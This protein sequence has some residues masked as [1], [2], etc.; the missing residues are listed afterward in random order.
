MEL[1]FN[2]R[3]IILILIY[4]SIARSLNAQKLP[5]YT[6]TNQNY[7]NDLK[8]F[9]DTLWVATSG[10]VFTM[11]FEDRKIQ[12]YATNNE[13]ADNNIRKVFIDKDGVKWFSSF[14]AI[15]EF[16]KRMIK[17]YAVPKSLASN[18]VFSFGKSMDGKLWIGTNGGEALIQIDGADTTK[19]DSQVFTE[20]VVWDMEGNGESLWFGTRDGAY[21]YNDGG[22]TRF[23]TPDG[24]IDNW[25][26]GLAVVDDNNVWIGTP[27][28]LTYY[29]GTSLSS[30]TTANSGIRDNY[31]VDIS[32][33]G[34]HVWLAS[35]SNLSYLKENIWRNISFGSPASIAVTEDGEAYVGT[36][37]NGISRV[38]EDG[39]VESILRPVTIP[40]NVIEDI[41]GDLDGNIWIATRGGLSKY[42]GFEFENFTTSSGLSDDFIFDVEVDE[43]NNVWIGT[44]REIAKYDGSKWESIA[45]EDVRSIASDG[46]GA[47][48]FGTISNGLFKYDGELSQFTTDDG[49]VSNSITSLVFDDNDVLWIGSSS[50]LMLYDGSFDSRLGSTNIRSLAVDSIN[51]VWAGTFDAGIMILEDRSL[52]NTLYEDDLFGGF[53]IRDIAFIDSKVYCT[54]EDGLGVYSEGEWFTYA[55]GDGLSSNIR[56]IHN[57]GTDLWVGSAGGLSFAK[58]KANQPPTDIALSKNQFDVE[59]ATP[60]RV[61]TL[62]AVDASK[63]DMHNF[64]ILDVSTSEADFFISENELWINSL[65]NELIETAEVKLKAVDLAGE[66][67]EIVLTI[68]FFDSMNDIPEITAYKGVSSINEDVP[69]AIKLEDFEVSDP[70][71]IFPEEFL[72]TIVQMENFS[73]T[74]NTITPNTDY[75]GDLEVSVIISDDENESTPFN[76]TVQVAPV[77]DIPEIVNQ[78]TELTISTETAIE[79]KLDYLNV[80]N[81]DAPYPESFSLNIYEGDHYSIS[82]FSVTPLVDFVGEL[83]VPISVNDGE[84]ESNIFEMTISV[85]PILAIQDETAEIIE[86]Y[87]N[88]VQNSVI[89]KTKE[90]LDIT[91]IVLLD[92][93]GRV[94]LNLNRDGFEKSDTFEIDLSKLN[95]GNYFIS[96]QENDGR[97]FTKRIIRYR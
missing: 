40:H 3:K 22:W 45:A 86:L 39:V 13:I 25:I 55:L 83:I 89:V 64:E 19:V 61:S 79:I 70:D 6:F 10:G 30:F 23:T 72:L 63:F 78:T 96:L 26:N 76:F 28:G 5:F 95:E 80:V 14:D 91:T 67:V 18:G 69:I 56:S 62:T 17:S 82:G 41:T 42:N 66:A 7:V 11:S 43:N 31:I 53:F 81:L 34:E 1:N 59:T 44:S 85:T 84:D 37:G 71:N 21:K 94:I 20:A 32:A 12:S 68:N 51:R 48:W 47:V 75:N 27:E 73:V 92:N 38:N 33:F 36:D 8:V 52:A 90:K 2:Y 58:I 9:K 97:I 88:P 4:C 35:R 50:G 93:S 15:F 60:A 16:D 54:T 49:L 24:L 29:D 87:P 65:D 57:G 46:Q 74:G 77:N